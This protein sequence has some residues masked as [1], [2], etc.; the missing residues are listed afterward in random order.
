MH[1]PFFLTFFASLAWALPGTS[2]RDVA[3]RVAPFCPNITVSA[4]GGVGPGCEPFHYYSSINIDGTIAT[5][6]FDKFV[7]DASKSS[8][9]CTTY[10]DLAYPMPVAPGCPNTGSFRVRRTGHNRLSG[11]DQSVRIENIAY[12]SGSNA[13]YFTSS[14]DQTFM[15]SSTDSQG[16]QSSPD[17]VDLAVTTFTFAAASDGSSGN[18]FLKDIATM[19]IYLELDLSSSTGQLTLD[20]LDLLV[21]TDG[22]SN[23]K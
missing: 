14:S 17:Y 23:A 1:I 18:S 13:D 21:V 9:N 7:I 16:T 8:L 4:I 3:P 10:I 19:S 11:K 22:H 12:P 20:S 15:Q 5:I 6:L 2:T